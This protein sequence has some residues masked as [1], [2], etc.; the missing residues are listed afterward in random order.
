MYAAG[1]CFIVRRVFRLIIFFAL[2]GV[3]VGGLGAAVPLVS[4]GM[5][6]L[7]LRDIGFCGGS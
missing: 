4:V 2:Y 7:C 1:C 3:F 5:G 6:I